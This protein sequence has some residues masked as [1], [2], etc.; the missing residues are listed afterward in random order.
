MTDVARSRPKG[1][2][3][4]MLNR[5]AQHRPITVA[6]IVWATAVVS[7]IVMAAARAAACVPQPL[8]WVQPK[9]SGPSSSQVT[10]DGIAFSPGPVEIRWNT[11]DGPLLLTAD[12]PTFNAVIAIP[13]SQ[14]GQYALLAFSRDQNGAV[15]VSARAAFTVT[16][17]SGTSV[18]PVIG[19][20]RSPR[21]AA[22][23]SHTISAGA[24][25]VGGAAIAII[26]G[27]LG[28]A[29]VRKLP[30]GSRSRA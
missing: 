25:A 21:T 19:S 9:A 7:G 12:G 6:S 28:G 15:G 17:G 2:A 3:T 11:I 13:P 5:R 27:A 8:I 29:V 4:Q 20:D 18:P 16:D 10:L 14:P 1:F 23:G 24:A 26:A 30:T 22:Q